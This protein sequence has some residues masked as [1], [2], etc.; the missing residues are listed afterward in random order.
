MRFSG[1]KPNDPDREQYQLWI[2]DASRGEPL[3][4]PPVDGGVFDAGAGGDV[5]VPIAPKLPVG[6]AFAFAV[7][8]EPPGGVVVSD[9]SRKVVLAVAP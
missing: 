9:Q 4:V 5:I 6:K 3:K 7:T 8:I 2:V 1:L